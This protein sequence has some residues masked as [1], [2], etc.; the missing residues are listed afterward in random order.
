M[1]AKSYQNLEVVGDVFTTKGRKYVQVRTKT[2]ALKTVR[3]YTEKEYAKMY[4]DEVVEQ[5]PSMKS[6]KQV[7]GFENGFITIFKGNTYE[8]KEYFKLN[9]AR[10]SR[11]WGWYFISTESI[12]EDLPDD[13]EPIRLDWELV[14]NEDGSLKPENTVIAAVESL[15]YEPDVSEYQGEVGDKVDVIVTV[16]KAIQLDGYYGPSTMHVFRDYDGNCYVWTTAARSWE[17]GSEHHIAGTIKELKQY[18]GTK[19]TILTRCREKS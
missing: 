16:E 12:P 1:V 5:G 11:W 17:V 10:Y 13:V 4:P 8:E 15:T 19:Q 2:G 14:G 6:Q 9:S 7:L 18:K 3:W